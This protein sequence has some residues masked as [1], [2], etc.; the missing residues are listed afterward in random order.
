[1]FGALGSSGSGGGR[2]LNLSPRLVSATATANATRLTASGIP[3][4]LTYSKM[5]GSTNVTVSSSGQ[6]SLGSALGPGGTASFVARVQN[7]AGVAME[8]SFT[9]TGLLATLT[10]SGTALSTTAPPG[11]VI[12]A[13]GN[14]AAGSTFSIV[15]P[16]G[17][18]AI[19]GSNLIVGLTPASV[20]SFDVTVRETP[21]AGSPKDT[22][23]TLTAA[24]AVS[25][26][27][28]NDL[29]IVVSFAKPVGATKPC[30]QIMRTSDSATVDIGYAANGYMDVAAINAVL[31]SGTWRYSKFYNHGTLAEDIPIPAGAIY[32]QITSDYFGFPALSMSGLAAGIPLP[33][34]LSLNNKLF[35][36]IMVHSTQTTGSGAAYFQLGTATN[37]RPTLYCEQNKGMMLFAGDGSTNL[38]TPIQSRTVVT[39]MVSNAANMTI[40][41][42]DT[43]ETR[44]AGTAGTIS[45]GWIGNTDLAPFPNKG[46]LMF[47]G[48]A[49]ADKTAAL[50]A[51]K[52]DLYTA[53]KVVRPTD[54]NLIHI[55]DSLGAGSG[56]TYGMNTSRQMQKQLIKQ[57]NVVNNCNPG[58]SLETIYAARALAIPPARRIGQKNAIVQMA[59][60]NSYKSGAQAQTL[61]DNTFIPLVQ[62]AFA[63]GI[64]AYFVYTVPPRSDYTAAQETQRLIGNDLLINGAATYGYKVINIC[65]DPA[66]DAQPS[67]TADAT[68]LSIYSGDGI[69]PINAGYLIHASY[70]MTIVNP[71]LAAA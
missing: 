47:F 54:F 64:D 15:P 9:L 46:D 18:V 17:R 26:N 30:L 38:T 55:G 21:T 10:L 42:N 37:P 14:A 29:L 32:S 59:M 11:T 5:S 61:Y 19:S 25:V 57:T 20:G 31:G 68:N 70:G 24:D 16:D 23:F 45:G 51:I 22:T 58:Q 43:T 1:M 60:S 8:D 12:G 4:T 28:P 7:T 69:H 50:P 44:A 33:S 34:S 71:W 2:R 39:A 63:N 53:F 35:T 48:I 40:H 13:I 36:V 3:G 66:F 49:A 6:V 27:I 65:A 67:Y 41:Q 52:S 62:Y 56:S